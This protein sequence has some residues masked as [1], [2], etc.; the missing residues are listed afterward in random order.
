MVENPVLY[1]ISQVL[2]KYAIVPE[3]WLAAHNKACDKRKIN[4]VFTGRFDKLRVQIDAIRRSGQRGTSCLNYWINWVLW[5]VAVFHDNAH[6]F[7]NA[8][9]RDSLD[10]WG[11]ERWWVNAYEGDD[12]I[13]ATNPPLKDHQDDVMAFWKR[14]GYNMK[15]VYC[16]KRATFTGWN[17]QVNSKGL[18]N[19]M[20]PELRRSMDNFGVSTSPSAV[21]AVREGDA[22]TLRKIAASAAMAKAVN[23]MGI[24]PQVSEKYLQ[25][26][27]TMGF[28]EFQ[29]EEQMAL[30]GKLV[31]TSEYTPGYVRARNV[32]VSAEHSLK[33]Y[34]SLGHACTQREIDK[35]MD[36]EWRFDNVTNWDGFAKSIPVG[37]T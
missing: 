13:I 1:H 2:M 17:F 5:H 22:E 36:Y 27:E 19:N 23:F 6:E 15:I 30:Y 24:F 29:H 12:S 9:R 20:A 8:D 34:H 28:Q 18:T 10:R 16:D 26:A 3:C 33:K 25:Y 32:I 37:W 11:E 35:F 4:L 31:D 21:R 7:L 14:M